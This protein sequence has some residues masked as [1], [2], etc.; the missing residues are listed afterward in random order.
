M[1]CRYYIHF[2]FQENEFCLTR[3][4]RA[5]LVNSTIYIVRAE[6]VIVSWDLQFKFHPGY[7]KLKTIKQINKTKLTRYHLY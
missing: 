3:Y 6:L 1:E 2:I 7:Y 5:T 4:F